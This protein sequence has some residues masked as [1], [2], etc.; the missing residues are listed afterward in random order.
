MHDLLSLYNLF[1]IWLLFYHQAVWCFS[2]NYESYAAIFQWDKMRTAGSSVAEWSNGLLSDSLL[3]EI[4]R[5]SYVY[6][7]AED[8]IMELFAIGFFIS[9]L[10]VRLYTQNKSHK[11][12]R[13][14]LVSHLK[15]SR[16]NTVLGSSFTLDP[17]ASLVLEKTIFCES[18]KQ[19]MFPTKCPASSMEFVVSQ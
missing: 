3:Y 17:Y 15:H 7:C 8:L 2:S 19:F 4:F 16:L 14:C 1:A 11:Q 9:D 13:R 6:F 18:R 10:Q 12:R 5:L